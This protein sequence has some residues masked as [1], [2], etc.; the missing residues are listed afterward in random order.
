MK[1]WYRF[2]NAA[3]DPSVAEIFIVDLIGSWY[4]EF[5]RAYYGESVVTA[6]SFLAELAKLDDSV[7]SIKVHINSPGGDVFAAVNIAN[8]LRE[9][10]VAKG[11]TV[12]TIVDG[13]AA[14]AASIVMM[15]GSTI[16]IAD[17]ALV[18]VHNPYTWG[19]GN[20]KDMRKYA[21][22]LD[23]IRTAIVA[24]YKWHSKLSDDELIALLDAETWMDADEA[25]AR[26]FATDKVEG[27]K[28]AASI[29]P[30]ALTKLAVPDKFRARVDALLTPA[31]PEPQ[32][33]A[34]TEVLA[35]CSAEGLDLA[36]AQT[37]VTAKCTLVDVKA[38]IATE[39]DAR[40]KAKARADEITAACAVG[41][42][43]DLVAGFIASGMS[44][45]DVKQHLTIL[46]AKIDAARGNVDPSLNPDAGAGAT[47]P[48]NDL[49]PAAIY[50][51]RKPKNKEQ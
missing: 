23:T 28:A 34:A 42:H 43:Q 22:E 4:D 36:F 18:M 46:N 51:S 7:K 40:V 2:Q 24:T 13:L 29:D 16:R 37:L 41:K 3:A 19:V 12:E 25:I 35:E 14:S 50:E 49:D 33:A 44:A 39:K 5:W 10:Q 32:P 31:Q 45:A 21:D 20:A 30:K 48:K 6:K 47:P 38:R 26:G 8:A 11:R 27:F 9:Q 17:N 1:P 15:A